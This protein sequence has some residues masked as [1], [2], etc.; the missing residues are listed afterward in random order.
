MTTGYS[1]GEQIVAALSRHLRDD[2][3]CFT[4]LT[5]GAGAV[6]YGT[7]IPLAAMALAQRTHAPNLTILFAG[8]SVNPQ[9]ARLTRLPDLEFANEFLSLPAEA[10]ITSYPNAI[11]YKRGDVTAGFSVG[12]QVDRHGSLNSTLIGSPAAP[13]VRLVGPILQPLHFTHFGREFVMM[14]RHDARTF[15]DAVDYRSGAGHHFTAEQRRAAGLNPDAGP[16]VVVSPLGM[17]G[18]AGP[19]RTMSAISLHPGVTPALVR[20]RTGFEIQG[21]DS[22]PVT[23]EPTEEQVH[24]LRTL[25]DPN[26]VLALRAIAHED[27]TEV[28]R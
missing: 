26:D 27:F 12:A 16:S 20:A 15:V 8:W 13:R 17:F 1:L 19:E 28:T 6:S 14:P 2:D 9:L 7:C 3:T 25:V 10:H 4:G 11:G 22:A 5:T 18:F 23:P 21:L 24:V